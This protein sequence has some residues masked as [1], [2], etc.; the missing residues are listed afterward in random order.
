MIINSGSFT[1]NGNFSGYNTKGKRVHI[2]GRQLSALGFTRKQDA[3]GK[4]TADV[5]N[6]KTF[7]IIAEN[8]KFPAKI[9]PI[10]KLAVPYADGSLVME[11][12]TA[13]AVFATKQ[14]YIDAH[15]MDEV[16]D[17]E[18]DAAIAKERSALGLTPTSVQ[19]FASL[20]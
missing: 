15:V 11:R 5:A 20:S 7:F 14:E 8:K 4:D 2:Y 16:L 6:F 9:D 18:V 12:L 19:E 10:T 3:Q 1:A 17:A 13:T